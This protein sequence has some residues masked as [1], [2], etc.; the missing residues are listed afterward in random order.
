MSKN[1]SITT[2]TQTDDHSILSLCFL[3][4]NS[5]SLEVSETA[6]I[7]FKNNPKLFRNI[8]STTSLKNLTVYRKEY[9]EKGS[10]FNK[11]F[12]K[13]FTGRKES[14]KE[15]IFINENDI[16]NKVTRL[17]TKF[18]R[19]VD[20]NKEVLRYEE[21]QEFLNLNKITYN[22]LH[23]SEELCTIEN[24]KIFEN[25][26]IATFLITDK[27]S[28]DPSLTE[29]GY[30]LVATIDNKF[31]QYVKYT[32]ESMEKS[33]LFLMNYIEAIESNRLYDYKSMN[34]KE[35]FSID[36]FRQL[37][38]D[39][40]NNNR[41]NLSDD[42]IR[43]SEFGQACI[44]Y[45]RCQELITADV[46]KKIYNILMRKILPTKKTSLEIMYS[47]LSMFKVLYESVKKNFNHLKLNKLS[48]KSKI[49]NNIANT[50]IVETETLETFKIDREKIGYYIFS[51]SQSGLN[52]F[53]SNQYRT[54][55][56]LEQMN[57]YPSLGQTDEGV[58]YVTPIGINLA[59]NKVAMDQGVNNVDLDS[60]RKFRMLK[61]Q[62]IISNQTL[63]MAGLNNTLSEFNLSISS[64]KKSILKRA[65]EQ[66]IDPLIESKYFLGESSHFNSSNL[67]SFE[68]NQKEFSADFPKSALNL[69]YDVV[70]NV[71]L[72]RKGKAKNLNNI[73][74]SNP[75]SSTRRLMSDG[76]L[77]F[78]TLPPQIK[79]IVDT[80]FQTS[81]SI[82]P[83]ANN[84]T[85]QVLQETQ[86]NIY[87]VRIISGFKLDSSGFLDVSNPIFQ[88]IS[89][90]HLSSGKNMIAKCFEYENTSLG[91]VK[92]LSN[93]TIY[94][95]LLYIRGE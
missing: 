9:R 15:I 38:V 47:T 46:D 17:Q 81:S 56:I 63:G 12:S 32:L 72:S 89:E 3:N 1:F 49:S 43:N 71:F 41:I 92:D 39:F 50:S 2:E 61:S 31:D 22:D 74:L 24:L 6:R 90:E 4:M 11:C 26:S 36:V 58:K 44:D 52:K 60:L 28:V 67:E 55:Y 16:G 23:S 85:G 68:E 87:Q 14:H 86:M 19:T 42:Q 20:V 18:G 29:V 21:D 53:S 10:S 48:S 66:S 93:T 65:T 83:I 77:N 75:N 88:D 57:Y 35:S 13:L 79:S 40:L 59:G 73:K 95:N 94:N 62:K 34:F 76:S 25:D 84:E 51:N 80:S 27:L 70:P 5:V 54:R 45:Y 91:I 33:I 7:I 8:G 78:Q 37:G 82:D 64:P 30:R 69:I